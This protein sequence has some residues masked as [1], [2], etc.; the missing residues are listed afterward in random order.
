VAA[1]AGDG[2][3]RFAAGL[4]LLAASQL[5]GLL[6]LDAV[7]THGAMTMA[8]RDERGRAVAAPVMIFTAIVSLARPR[9]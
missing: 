6:A 4:V 9:R 8:V 3:K 5:I 7:M 1:A 2:W